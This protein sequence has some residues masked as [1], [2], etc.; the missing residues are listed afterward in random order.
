M[1]AQA[2]LDVGRARVGVQLGHVDGLGV[3]R[4][5]LGWALHHLT[6]IDPEWNR[7]W[8]LDWQR[9]H[10]VLADLAADEADGTLPA[11][12]PGVT[13]EGDD[14]GRWVQRQARDWAQLSAEQ[15]K[16]LTGLGIKPAERPCAAPVPEPITEPDRVDRLDVHRRDRLGGTLHEY[17]HAA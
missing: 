13:F 5:G 10:R 2:A 3:V 11:I 17:A 12:P 15:H 6:A 1:P 8:P 4:A 16:R 9:H 7:P 14:L